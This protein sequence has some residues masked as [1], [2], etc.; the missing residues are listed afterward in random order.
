MNNFEIA[1]CGEQWAQEA[2]AQFER[3]VRDDLKMELASEAIRE[4]IWRGIFVGGWENGALCIA[5]AVVNGEVIG[6]AVY[7]I[8][9][10][11]SD[12]CEREGWGCI[13]EFFIQPNYRGMGYG[14][15]LA[16]YAERE[17]REKA[18]RLYLT[19]DSAVG[20]WRACGY[21]KTDGRNENGTYTMTK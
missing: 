10:R 7:Q 14:R 18:E 2:E 15:R 13:R 1:E 19:A 5:L 21:E 3:Y 6:M 16:D 4:K 8:D 11:E 9:S 20:F 12:W 17:L